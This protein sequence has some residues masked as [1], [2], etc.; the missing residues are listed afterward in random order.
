MLHLIP[1][2]PTLLASVNSQFSGVTDEAVLISIDIELERL[3]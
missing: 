3:N 1:V 2:P